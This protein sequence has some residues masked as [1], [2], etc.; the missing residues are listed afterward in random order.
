VALEIA[1]QSG[2]LHRDAD[3]PGMVHFP[4]EILRE[5][6][7]DASS[8]VDR[9]EIHTRIATALL[10]W[11]GL[12][13]D[14]SEL[15]AYHVWQAESVFDQEAPAHML[16]AG[17]QAIRRRAYDEAE[18]WFRRGL[19]SLAHRPNS[20]AHTETATALRRHLA[21]VLGTVR[22]WSDVEAMSL[23][24]RCLAAAQ[25]ARDATSLQWT[26]CYTQLV[27]GRYDECLPH[28]EDLGKVA[29]AHG[30]PLAKAGYQF[31]SGVIMH[32]RGRF[33]EALAAFDAAIEHTDPFPGGD[34]QQPT[35]YGLRVPIRTYRALTLSLIGDQ[36]RATRQCDEL[37]LLTER[38][39][40]PYDRAIALYTCSMV[41][42]LGG[43][44]KTALCTSQEGLGLAEQYNLRCGRGMLQVVRGWAE[45]QIYSGDEGIAMM[46]AAIADLSAMGTV[47]RN[48]LHLSLL[49]HCLHG[50]ERADEEAAVRRR[51]RAE[52]ALRGEYGYSDRFLPFS[53]VTPLPVLTS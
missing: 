15:I 25:D 5:A 38:D 36:T 20:P 23:L 45:T 27:S 10:A 4:Y 49:A 41:A 7:V 13:C 19:R 29:A 51:I 2:W 6:L 26:W 9:T 28:V 21:I 18:Q 46:R 32:V 34:W 47:I 42:A 22:G 48:T 1:T 24:R 50:A 31:I 53:D 37:L 40:T 39:A 17:Q 16:R 11:D 43:D 30:D 35:T 12:G 3:R 33:V 14:R 52:I 44:A 8:D